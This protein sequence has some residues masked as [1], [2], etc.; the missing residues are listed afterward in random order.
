[1]TLLGEA[2]VAMWWDIAPEYRA[3]F[4]DWHSHEHFPERMSI[5][6]FMRGS[7]WASAEGGDGFF[8]MYELESYATLTSPHYLGS[9]NNPT[10]WSKKMMPHHRNMVRSQC[11]IAESYGGGIGRAMMTLRLSPEKG[12]EDSLRQH[13]TSVLSGLP[14]RP[15]LTGAHLLFTQTPNIAQT[16]EQRIRG[17]DAVAD[18]I[19]LVSGYDA[20]AIAAIVESELGADRLNEAGAAPVAIYSHFNLAYAMTPGDIRAQ[21]R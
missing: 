5:P 18:W 16:N 12:A 10:P 9:L 3:A 11:H 6:G 7:R 13:L 21:S 20:D 8:V 15:G 1:M 2:A 17:G 14:A 4:E 19:V